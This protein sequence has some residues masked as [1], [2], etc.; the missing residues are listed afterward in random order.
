MLQDASVTTAKLSLG[1]RDAFGTPSAGTGSVASVNLDPDTYQYRRYLAPIPYRRSATGSS[2]VAVIGR[3]YL[4]PLVIPRKCILDLTSTGI[5]TVNGNMRVGIYDGDSGNGA[6]NLLYDSGTFPV[7]APAV[8]NMVPVLTLDMS[9]ATG[10][11]YFIAIMFDNAVAA[12][13]RAPG[14]AFWDINNSY[15]NGSFFDNSIGFGAFDPGPLGAKTKSTTAC[16][17]TVLR[18]QSVI[19]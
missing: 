14:V 17:A 16:H 8:N 9:D 10:D 15:L 1:T 7:A 11:L 18:V 2:S 4:T 5:Q 12:F 13:Y 19:G 3:V 6:I